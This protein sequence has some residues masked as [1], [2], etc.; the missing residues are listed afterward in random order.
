MLCVYRAGFQDTISVQTKL[1]CFFAEASCF[2]WLQN[3]QLFWSC[4]LWA[5]LYYIKIVFREICFCNFKN[6]TKYLVCVSLTTC[7][8]LWHPCGGQGCLSFYYVGSRDQTQV[9]GCQGLMWSTFIH[10][11]LFEGQCWNILREDLKW[12]SF[13]VFETFG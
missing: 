2:I 9:M 5:A 8:L 11:A 13:V 7:A 3:K 12:Y 4:R 1:S 6:K 10:W